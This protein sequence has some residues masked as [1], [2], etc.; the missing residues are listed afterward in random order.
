MWD[1]NLVSRYA[2]FIYYDRLEPFYPVRIGV[3][4]LS[5]AGPSPSFSRE[6]QFQDERLDFIIEYA[7]YYDYDIQHLYDLEH[8]WI[9]VAKD[10]S[11]LDCEASFHGKYLRGLLK[12]RSNLEQTHVRLYSQ[13]G[14]HAFAPFVQLFDLIPNMEACTDVDAGKAG[15]I[16][17]TPFKGAYET[18]DEINHSVCEF[19]QGYRFKPSMEFKRY[20]LPEDI[21]VTW[22]TLHLEIPIRIR[23]ILE[24]IMT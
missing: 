2:P 1:L 22:E 10:G 6:F 21:Y 18:N 9:Y 15:L 19:L 13:P 7:V 11:V 24:Q 23:H 12:D 20:I 16:V 14:K 17:T 3:T 8:V 5:Q 4:V